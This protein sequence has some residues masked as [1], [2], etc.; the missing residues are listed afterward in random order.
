MSAGAV[1]D[2]RRELSK[3]ERLRRV[4]MDRAFHPC[5]RLPDDVRWGETQPVGWFDF[6]ARYKNVLGIYGRSGLYFL[7]FLSGH[8]YV[9]MAPWSK[10]APEDR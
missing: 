7:I 10:L 2:L 8:W 9:A 1:F 6:G 5:E 3:H 4:G